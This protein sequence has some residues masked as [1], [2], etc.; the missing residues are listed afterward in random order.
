MQEKPHRSRSQR[1]NSRLATAA[2]AYQWDEVRSLVERGADVNTADSRGLRPL[3]Y[4]LNGRYRSKYRDE[5]R[6][7]SSIV[8]LLLSQGAKFGKTEL[9]ELPRTGNYGEREYRKWVT[10]ENLE[11]DVKDLRFESFK[12]SAVEI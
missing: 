8:R 1:R 9:N 11:C 6:E 2:S 12:D 7:A 3:V 5:E 10:K 4:A